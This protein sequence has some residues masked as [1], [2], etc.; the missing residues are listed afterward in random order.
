MPIR[1]MKRKQNGGFGRLSKRPVLTADEAMAKAEEL[2]RKNKSAL[3]EA[4]LETLAAVGVM[5]TRQLMA[6]TGI[7]LRSLEKYHHLNWLD[8][9]PLP[10]GIRAMALPPSR[11]PQ[12]LYTLGI[13]GVAYAKVCGWVAETFSGYNF[14]RTTHDVLCN[15]VALELTQYVLTHDGSYEWG[16]AYESR[17]YNSDGEVILEPDALL[18]FSLPNGKFAIYALEYHNEDDRRRVG[19]KVA[20]YEGACTQKRELNRYWGTTTMPAVL[21]SFS[22]K[23]VLDGYVGVLRELGQRQIQCRY[24]AK[25]IG[26]VLDPEDDMTHWH[27]LNHKAFADA[28]RRVNLFD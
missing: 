13:V 14:Y 7:K 1:S 15:Q 23:I 4:V 12:R 2:K 10:K 24:L 18:K 21:I 27:D 5:T 17:L 20:R 28:W 11:F 16:G 19:D 6:V 8:W 9:W 3:A 25:S 26:K 22:H